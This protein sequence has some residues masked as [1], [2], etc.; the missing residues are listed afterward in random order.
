MFSAFT[1]CFKIPE[2]RNRILFTLGIILIIRVGCAIPTPGV[3]AAVLGHYFENVVDSEKGGSVMALFNIFSGGALESCAIFSLG[4]MPYISASIIIQLLTAVIPRLA[5]IA[6]EEG[7]RQKITQYNRYLTLILCLFQGGLL[8][9][10]F[11][12]P[13]KNP[14]LPGIAKT[15]ESQGPLVSD[16]GFQ[17]Y[18]VAVVTLTAGTMFMMWL[19][20]Q[21]TERGIGQGISIIVM[22][23]ILARLPAAIMQAYTL[24]SD[25]LNLVVILLLVLFLFGVI[26]AVVAVTSAERKIPV[27]IAKRMVGQKLMGGQTQHIPLKVNYA[28]V[29]PIIFAQAILVFPQTLLMVPQLQSWSG[30]NGLM[31]MINPGT[32]LHAVLYGLMIFF[33]SYFWVSTQF[34][35]VQIADD[36]KKNGGYIPGRQPGKPT[37]DFLAYTMTRLTL[38]G[39]A[40]LTVIALLPEI[41][42][43]NMGVPF[44]TAQFFGGTSLLIAVGVV[45]DSMRQAETFLLQRHYDG[46]LKKGRATRGRG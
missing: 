2:L 12:Y 37:A 36:L 42:S 43:Y 27:Q 20:E 32:V 34:N 31:S 17:Y 39:A 23:G 8:A 40:F 3:N 10:G 6:R 26:A 22:I 21:I 28:G 41:I 29:M 13:E 46:F 25:K 35:P 4:I 33:F 16:V 1:N 9:H 14:L 38:A 24:F 15:I 30:F 19:G 45:L 44:L 11:A 5:K 18:F 7:G